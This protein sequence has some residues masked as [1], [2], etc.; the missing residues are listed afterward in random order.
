MAE[1]QMNQDTNFVGTAGISGVVTIR[2][3][4][5]RNVPWLVKQISNRCQTTASGA[6]AGI[7]KN[8]YPITP[9]VPGFDAAGG[10]PP[11]QLRPSDTMTVDY[12]GLNVGDVV[13][14][15]VV[16]DETEWSG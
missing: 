4:P 5:K 6:T 11:I 7:S 10:D 13:Q 15:L 1:L 16:Y 8:G 3:Q 12:T 9:L 14:V 2:I